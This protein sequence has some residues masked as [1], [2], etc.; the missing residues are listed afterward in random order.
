M[1]T[2]TTIYANVGWVGG[3]EKVQKCADVIYV[4]Q[5]AVTRSFQQIPKLCGSLLDLNKMKK[6]R[7]KK[8]EKI[9]KRKKNLEKSRLD[10]RSLF[11]RKGPTYTVNSNFHF[12][13]LLGTVV[14]MIK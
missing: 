8:K 1:L 13:F 10:R 5:I 14:K 7:K 12:Y 11:R 2:F 6:E 4:L 3:S 9:K